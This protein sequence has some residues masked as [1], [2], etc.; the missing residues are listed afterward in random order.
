MNPGRRS[1][2]A[3]SASLAFGIPDEHAINRFY[4]FLEPGFFALAQMRAR[5][6]HQKRQF[7]LI[8]ANQFFRK[9]PQRIGVKL[10]ISS[11]EID[12]IIRVRENR[13]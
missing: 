10:R 12:Q 6:Q 3:R 9:S 7:Q 11:G 2:P 13:Q 8:G 5:M 1:F 4:D